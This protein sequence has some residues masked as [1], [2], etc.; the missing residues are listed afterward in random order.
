MRVPILV[1]TLLSLV[2][3]YLVAVFCYAC[4]GSIDGILMILAINYYCLF[5][6][7]AH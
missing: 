5:E 1:Y 6:C 4:V 7:I 2:Y 3:D